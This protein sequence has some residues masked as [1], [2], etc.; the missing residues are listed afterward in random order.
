MGP[1]PAKGD[2]SAADV[3][4]L[5]AYEWEKRIMPA[6]E[7]ADDLGALDKLSRCVYFAKWKA[8]SQINALVAQMQQSLQT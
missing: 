6:L 7:A 2:F 1:I 8:S 5:I 3:K 4:Q